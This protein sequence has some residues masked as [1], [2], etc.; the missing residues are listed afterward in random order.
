MPAQPVREQSRMLGALY[1]RLVTDFPDV[2]G[3]AIAACILEARAVVSMF[4]LEPPLIGPMIERT[5][6][7]HVEIRLGRARP[8]A[9]LMPERHDRPR[10][11]ATG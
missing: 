5:V 9:R 3:A 1:E 6:R 2:A 4:G 7:R 8:A 11:V 10:V